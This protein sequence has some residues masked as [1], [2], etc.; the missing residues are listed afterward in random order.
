MPA[1]PVVTAVSSNVNASA[2]ETFTPGQLFSAT[3]AE[4]F[5]ILNYEVEDETVGGNNG[6]WVLDGAVLPNGQLTTLTAAQLSQ[7][8][9][10]A[11]SASAPVTDTLEWRPRIRRGS[12]RWPPSR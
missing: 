2:S 6:F 5:P 4:G 9:F 10:V 8:T 7:L 3:E 11:G 12:G 1:T